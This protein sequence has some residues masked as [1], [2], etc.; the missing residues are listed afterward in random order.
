MS[1]A[2]PPIFEASIWLMRYGFTSTFSCFVMLNVIG[3]VRR[4]VVTLSSNAEQTIVRPDRA[5]SRAIGLAFTRCAAHIARKLNK[6]VS[7]VMF[8]MIIMP[9][10]RPSVLKSICDIAV[11][12]SMMPHNIISMAPQIP[13]M[14]R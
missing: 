8:T 9:M 11:C 14:V 3:T 5:I 2:V 1:V 6:P 7:L 4:T 10:S 13:T 12:W